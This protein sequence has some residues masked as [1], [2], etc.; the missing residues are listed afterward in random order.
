MTTLCKTNKLCLELGMFDPLVYMY[1]IEWKINIIFLFILLYF[2]GKT[3][4]L[5]SFTYRVYFIKWYPD[6]IF[7]QQLYAN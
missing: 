7:P 5:N 4:K 1:V 3:Y 2:V 6:S